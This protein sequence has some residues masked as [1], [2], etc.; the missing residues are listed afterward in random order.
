MFFLAQGYGFGFP[1]MGG[2]A[3]AIDRALKQEKEVPTAQLEP[4]A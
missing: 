3:I 4:A 2:L 1:V